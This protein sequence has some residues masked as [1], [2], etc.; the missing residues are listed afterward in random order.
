MKHSGTGLIH[1]SK[2]RF[3]KGVASIE[4]VIV[5]PILIL[6]GFGVIE[7]ARAIQ[8]NNM[9]SNLTR[10]GAN[11]ASRAIT[12]TSQEVMDALA[13]SADPLQ[14]SQDGIIY[15]TVVVGELGQNPY[16]SEQH[17]WLN[18]GYNGA[19]QIWSTCGTWNADGSCNISSPPPRLSNFPISLD[20]G[21]T[22]HVVEVVYDFS[23][24]TS[25]ITNNNLTIYSQSFM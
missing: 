20:P 3:I 25:Y 22:A 6:L 5:V 8:A 24:L 12:S 7:L 1:R 23:L 18:S 16:I 4:M 10:E 17:R 9:A 11:L 2:H 14:L 21:E 19:S 13:L 15:I